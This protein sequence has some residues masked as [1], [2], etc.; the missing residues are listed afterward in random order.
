M[1]L[2]IVIC[3]TV[4]IE[5]N[6]FYCRFSLQLHLSTGATPTAGATPSLQ[7][8][9]INP[10]R[11]LNHIS[12]KLVP[13]SD[14]FLKKHLAQNILDMKVQYPLVNRPPSLVRYHSNTI[15]L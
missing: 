3:I 15:R 2:G 7:V 6:L 12:L 8:V 14:S 1:P 9:E 11:H 13:A 5:S 4:F 10:F